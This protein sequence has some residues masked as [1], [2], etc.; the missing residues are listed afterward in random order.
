MRECDGGRPPCMAA[1]RA[2]LL[3]E[4]PYALAVFNASRGA[5]VP[6]GTDEEAAAL[7]S[8]V[9]ARQPA[10]AWL[11]YTKRTRGGGASA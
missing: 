9:A 10:E 8:I 5:N 6:A 1:T 4:R 11:Q 2:A 7:L 3:R